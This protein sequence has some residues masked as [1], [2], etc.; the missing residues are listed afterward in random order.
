MSCVTKLW[1]RMKTPDPATTGYGGLTNWVLLF[2]IGHYCVFSQFPAS[3]TAE[4]CQ[5]VVSRYLKTILSE[6]HAFYLSSKLL[7][8]IKHCHS[9]CSCATVLSLKHLFCH[10][11][12]L[13]PFLRDLMLLSLPNSVVP[14]LGSTPGW[15]RQKSQ[16]RGEEVEGG[17]GPC[18]PVCSYVKANLKE[19]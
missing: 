16:G 1:R 3:D 14:N 19:E 18:L 17:T 15:R 8:N 2:L 5:S 11:L 7:I 10:L 9:L 12:C 6:A 4:I 13:F